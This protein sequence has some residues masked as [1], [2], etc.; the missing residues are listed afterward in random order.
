MAVSSH[1]PP[2]QYNFNP[3]QNGTYCMLANA[4]S[5]ASCVRFT[6]VIICHVCSLLLLYSNQLCEYP[7]IDSFNCHWKFAVSRLFAKEPVT[8]VLF[9]GTP[10][11]RH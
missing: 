7:L 8:I 1:P 5:S 10:E 4:V 3:L 11:H 9:S 2:D 6:H